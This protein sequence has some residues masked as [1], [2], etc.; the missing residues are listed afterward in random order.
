MNK[1]YRL[2]SLLRSSATIDTLLEKKDCV[3]GLASR[4]AEKIVR[5]TRNSG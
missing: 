2:F 1:P 3:S 4:L 5:A